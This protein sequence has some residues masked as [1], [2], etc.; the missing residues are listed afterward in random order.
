MHKVHSIPDILWNKPFK[1]FV[2]E[3]YDRWT[4]EGVHALT[5][6]RNI[7]APPRR[8]I[9]ARILDAWRQLEK[10][11]I[12]KSFRCC[13]L[14]L[15]PDV[16]EDDE[17]HCF[18]INQPCEKGKERFKLLMG[19]LDETTVDPFAGIQDVESM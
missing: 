17:I 16:S 14:C 9:V 19:T 12:I 5:A 13:V 1:Q 2:T 11:V 10:E 4:T 3:Q 6:A 8:K 18:Q 15:S 7:K